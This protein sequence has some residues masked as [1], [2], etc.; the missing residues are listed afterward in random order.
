MIHIHSYLHAVDYL[1]NLSAWDPHSCS[2][3]FT[4]PVSMTG[5]FAVPLEAERTSLPF[6]FGLSSVPYT[7]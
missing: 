7:G 4:F 2:K 6:N 5:N 3:W 1:F